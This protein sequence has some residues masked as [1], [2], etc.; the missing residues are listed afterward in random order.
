MLGN[1]VWEQLVNSFTSAG[2][3]GWSAPISWRHHRELRW[4]QL[5]GLPVSPCMNIMK[6]LK[7]KVYFSLEQ[8]L[9]HTL[10]DT[11]RHS[12]PSGFR[13]LS[14]STWLWL[15]RRL[16]M[17]W[18]IGMN[19]QAEVICPYFCSITSRKKCMCQVTCL[20]LFVGLFFSPMTIMGHNQPVSAKRWLQ[21]PPKSDHLHHVQ[22]TF[23]GSWSSSRN[24]K[25]NKLAHKT[26]PS[27]TSNHPKKNRKNHP[28]SLFWGQLVVAIVDIE[29][30]N[31]HEMPL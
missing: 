17:E 22:N 23:K 7:T 29:L 3:S 12:P 13:S 24:C 20:V 5:Y 14:C 2:T 18:V 30:V 15:R 31:Q 1:T 26:S 8:S 11:R 10:K 16:A 4:T 25:Q 9:T 27:Y 21:R 6:T 19:C 28:T